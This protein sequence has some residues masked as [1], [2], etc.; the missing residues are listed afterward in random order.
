[1]SQD[2]MNLPTEEEDE[3]FAAELAA[4]RANREQKEQ[5]AA[6][7]AD[8]A[9]Q[10]IREGHTAEPGT[11][12]LCVLS[13]TLNEAYVLGEGVYQGEEV[14][15]P[16]IGANMDLDLHRM[17]QANPKILLDSGEVVW[18]CECW[19]APIEEMKERIGNRKCIPTTIQEL[20]K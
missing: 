15:P 8:K 11:R 16:G 14:P 4:L 18:G 2:W 12:V 3:D 6:K 20:R 9:V 19:W 7:Q 5:E 10:K 17:G 13:M 1:M